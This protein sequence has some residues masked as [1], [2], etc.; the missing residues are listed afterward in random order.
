[1]IG[2]LNGL[3]IDKSEKYLLVLAQSVGYKVNVS[4][5]QIAEVPVDQKIQLFIHTAVREDD[6]SL[7]GF[8]TKEEMRFF[9]QLI[10]V[11]GI[12]PRMAMDILS[13]PIGMTQRAIVE[14]DTA[15]L[16]KIK[17]LG[18]KTAERL[19]LELRNKITPDL[20]NLPKKEGGVIAEDAVLAL[21]SLGYDRFEIVK[22]MRN[23]P[24]EI[25]KTEEVV[26]YFLRQS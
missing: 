5:K 9:E 6:I 20:E 24:R 2:Y 26:K 12:G 14:G 8:A 4:L 16:T 10:G 1:M 13:T 22:A 3:V 23:I 25:T 19:I 15:L 21:E 17:G 7:Y 18:K 11:S